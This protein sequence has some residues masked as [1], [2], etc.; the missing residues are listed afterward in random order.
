MTEERYDEAERISENV[1]TYER[2]RG[3]FMAGIVI[4]AVILFGLLFFTV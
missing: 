3:L 1:G 4:S 2:M